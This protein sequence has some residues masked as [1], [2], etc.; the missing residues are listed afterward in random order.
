MRFD[1]LMDS[2]NGREQLEQRTHHVSIVDQFT[3]QSDA[4]AEMPGHSHESA[5]RLMIETSGVT[6]TDTVLDVACGPGLVS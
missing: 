4:F 2:G 6:S 3:K 5:F 1:L